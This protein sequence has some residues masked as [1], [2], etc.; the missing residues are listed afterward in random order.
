MDIEE[1]AK[2]IS[3]KRIENSQSQNENEDKSY[4][5]IQKG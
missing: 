3:L 1:D 5:N 2:S 4:T